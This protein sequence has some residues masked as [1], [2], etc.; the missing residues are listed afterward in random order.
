MIDAI[1]EGHGAVAFYPKSCRHFHSSSRI[2][3][4]L[5]KKAGIPLLTIDGDCIDNRGDDFLV[6]KTRIDRFM[7]RLVQHAQDYDQ[8]VSTQAC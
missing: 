7:K 6:L 4:E 1:P 5:F 8:L 3:A 2:E